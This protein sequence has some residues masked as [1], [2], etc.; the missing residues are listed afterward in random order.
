MIEINPK[1]DMLLVVDVQNDF[2]DGSLAVPDGADVVPVINEYI[3][4]IPRKVFSKDA[5]PTSHSSFADQGGSWPDHCV[6]GTR[7][8]ELHSDLDVDE[9]KAFIINKGTELNKDA[10]SA[11][12][13]TGFDMVLPGMGVKRLFICGLA[14][15]YCVKATV[16]DAI[17]L[18]GIEVYVLTDAIKAVNVNPGDGDKALQEMFDAGAIP[19]VLAEI[20]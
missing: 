8:S 19:L 16:L 11:F 20:K 2:I 3:E 10:Y 9:Q 1:T 13:G 5:H 17:K 6:V 4:K 18:N 15:D 7:G 12:D 14:T